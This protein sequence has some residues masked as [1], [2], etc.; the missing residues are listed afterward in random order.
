[1]QPLT[2]L[3]GDLVN[4]IT[5]IYFNSLAGSIK[6]HLAVAAPGGMG[7]NLFE[8]LRADVTVEIIG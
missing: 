8:Q 1:V 7:A 2:K 5:S 4:L 3:V 6:D